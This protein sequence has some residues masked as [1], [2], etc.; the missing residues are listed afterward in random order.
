MWKVSVTGKKTSWWNFTHLKI[1][2]GIIRKHFFLQTF[3]LIINKFYHYIQVSPYSF[4]KGNWASNI[5]SISIS[6]HICCFLVL[7]YM[8][9][10]SGKRIFHKTCYLWWSPNAN[11]TIL[12]FL[13]MF[14]MQ[15]QL[16]YYA[17]L[18][19]KEIYCTRDAIHGYF[20]RNV[21]CFI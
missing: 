11:T 3:C 20:S 21:H 16:L 19:N 8:E 14:R 12:C 4:S 1:S 7:F 10:S 13:P 15:W 9:N 5:Y 2:W 6:I 17:L 18:W